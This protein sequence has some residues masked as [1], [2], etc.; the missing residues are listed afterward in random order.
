MLHGVKV[1][2]QKQPGALTWS[3]EARVIEKDQEHYVDEIGVLI[4]TT[5]KPSRTRW[6]GCPPPT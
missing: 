6:P 3:S 4:K 5:E 1:G 2:L